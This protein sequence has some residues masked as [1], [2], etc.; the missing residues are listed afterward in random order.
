METDVAFHQLCATITFFLWYH[1]VKGNRHPYPL[2]CHDG[3]VTKSSN[4]LC[5]FIVVNV[6]LFMAGEHRQPRGVQVLGK[7]SSGLRGLVL[8][9]PGIPMQ[10]QAL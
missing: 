9:I 7:C 8:L 1:K 4:N 6:S 10:D 2:L 5:C 3:V